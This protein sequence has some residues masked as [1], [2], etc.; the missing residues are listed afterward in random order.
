MGASAAEVA[1]GSED[2]SVESANTEVGVSRTLSVEDCGH[3]RVGP[4]ETGGSLRVSLDRLILGGHMAREPLIA[5][6][7]LG[8]TTGLP[9]CSSEPVANDDDDDSSAGLFEDRVE[10]YFGSSTATGITEQWSF[11]TPY[12]VRRSLF[13]SDSLIVEELFNTDDGTLFEVELEVDAASNTFSLHFADGTYTGAGTLTGNAWAWN[14]WASVATQVEDGSTVES[15][16]TLTAQ[17][18]TVSKLGR[19]AS[20][21][22]QWSA[23]E[24]FAVIDEAEW[25]QRFDALPALPE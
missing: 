9:A 10:L 3:T 24:S 12:L 14:A 5:L 1:G 6:F 18:L 25:Q 7:V 8:L 21:V 20:G 2:L 15:T 13:P 23:G 11:T 22:P 4:R 16:D 19:D 17:Y